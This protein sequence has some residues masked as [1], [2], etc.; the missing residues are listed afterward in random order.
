MS[1][2]SGP[3]QSGAAR[4]LQQRRRVEAAARQVAERERDRARAAEYVE[5]E[6][7]TKAELLQLVAAAMPLVGDRWGQR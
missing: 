6:P 1:R 7:L 3:Q 2:F 4:D 5:P